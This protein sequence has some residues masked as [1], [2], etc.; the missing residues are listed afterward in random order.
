M[1]IK[2]NKQIK[3]RPISGKTQLLLCKLYCMSKM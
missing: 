1:A 3:E 2:T